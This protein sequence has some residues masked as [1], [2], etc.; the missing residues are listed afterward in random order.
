LSTRYCFDLKVCFPS[1]SKNAD[2][3]FPS[4]L[5]PSPPLRLSDGLP[6][7]GLS[8][9]LRSMVGKGY[10]F[11]PLDIVS[12]CSAFP[13]PPSRFGLCIN[14]DTPHTPELSFYRRTMARLHFFSP[15]CINL[16]CL[17]PKEFFLVIVTPVPPCRPKC[18]SEL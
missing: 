18:P 4:P 3:F 7:I 11:F 10:H 6:W 2:G 14:F 1:F 9:F 12:N 13:L 8:P 16:I 5:L 17:L 15:P